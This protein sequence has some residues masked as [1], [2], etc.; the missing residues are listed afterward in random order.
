MIEYYSKRDPERIFVQLLG[1][2]FWAK[3]F[4]QKKQLF[5]IS[6]FFY[7][8]AKKAERQKKAVEKKGFVRSPKKIIN[9]KISTHYY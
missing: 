4:G 7:T 8:H 3:N 1:K 5:L 6:S 9:Y 2:K